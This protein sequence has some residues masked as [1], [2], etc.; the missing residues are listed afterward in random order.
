MNLSY[1]YQRTLD[2]CREFSCGD[3]ANAWRKSRKEADKDKD[4]LLQLRK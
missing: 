1:V 2:I 3:E 4:F